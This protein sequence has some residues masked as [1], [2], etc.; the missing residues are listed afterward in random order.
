M[1]DKVLILTAL[2]AEARAIDRALPDRHRPRVR[3][4]TVGIACRRLPRIDSFGQPRWI[5]VAGLAGALDPMLKVGDLVLDDPESVVAETDFRRGRILT[6]SD[7]LATPADKAAAFKTSGAVAVDME[8]DLIR[9]KFAAANLPVIGLRAIS[10]RADQTLD[11]AVVRMVTDTGRPRPLRVA[12][13]LIR[14]P[15]LAGYLTTLNADTQTALEQLGIGI[16]NLL[17]AIP[18]K[19]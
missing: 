12:V 9:L 19:T 16:V 10:D 2:T 18:L 13:E 4:E 7:I 14:R 17:D 15:S 1:A 5:V 3:V 8:Q 6:V 11:P